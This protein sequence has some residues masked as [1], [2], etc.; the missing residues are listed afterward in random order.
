MRGRAA[1][2]A[3]ALL[4]ALGCSSDD[5]DTRAPLADEPL[6]IGVAADGDAVPVVGHGRPGR[7]ARAHL[8]TEGSEAPEPLPA[9]PADVWFVESSAVATERW[10]AVL[11]RTC[12]EPLGEDEIGPL[13]REGERTGLLALDRRTEE[14]STVDVGDLGVG[15]E[16]T[17]MIGDVVEVVTRSPRTGLGTI[18]VSQADGGPRRL[19]TLDPADA[20]CADREGSPFLVDDGPLV[21]AV[22][23]ALADR[24]GACR[25]AAGWLLVPEPEAGG[26]MGDTPY[27][28]YAPLRLDGPVHRGRGNVDAMT[29]GQGFVALQ[30]GAGLVVVADDGRELAAPTVEGGDGA[31]VVRAL[32][33]ALVV[34][35]LD[36]D[37]HLR[38][39]AVHPVDA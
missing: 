5:D 7:P 3:V 6:T 36:D 22:G 37:G 1:I 13:C 39:V 11:G 27:S 26:A 21:P 35:V 10:V 20:L 19:R 31:M 33:D 15:A 9:L 14:W 38:S 28:L 17:T 32:A 2:V 34:A 4:T 12:P 25:S 8:V 16:L 18:D 30:V 23:E 24:P 29:A